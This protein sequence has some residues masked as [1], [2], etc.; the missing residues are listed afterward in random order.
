MFCLRCKGWENALKTSSSCLR[1]TMP[2]ASNLSVLLGFLAQQRNQAKVAMPAKK[3]WLDR[4]H[5]TIITIIRIITIIININN[6]YVTWHRIASY[7][8]TLR[9]IPLY[10]YYVMPSSWNWSETNKQTKQ[11][12]TKQNKHICGIVLTTSTTVAAHKSAHAGSR[13]WGFI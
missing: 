13:N 6:T 2:F 12:K 5:N 3:C 7:R 8:N 11:N 4:H 10:A 1:L 9:H